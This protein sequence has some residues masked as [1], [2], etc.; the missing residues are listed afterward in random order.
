[1]RIA[2]KSTL[3]QVK[4]FYQNKVVVL[5]LWN[6]F[7]HSIVERIDPILAIVIGQVGDR[8]KAFINFSRATNMVGQSGLILHLLLH[9]NNP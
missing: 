9:I 2:T 3:L 7:L 8:L 1:M 4:V 5:L 6:N